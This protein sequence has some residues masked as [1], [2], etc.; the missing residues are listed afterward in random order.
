[1]INIG[2]DIDINVDLGGDKK[3]SVNIIDKKE[4][5]EPEIIIEKRK[6]VEESKNNIPLSDKNTG[7]LDNKVIEVDIINNN[8][9]T[10]K[11]KNILGETVP[12]ENKVIKDIN[13]KVHSDS[14]KNEKKSRTTKR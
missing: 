6:L 1:M 14:H 9:E 3:D 2:K 5:P 12:Q 10:N 8:E 4:L 13:L 11:K 7:M